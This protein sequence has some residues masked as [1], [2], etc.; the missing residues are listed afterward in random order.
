MRYFKFLFLFVCTILLQACPTPNDEVLAGKLSL[1]NNSSED[2]YYYEDFSINMLNSTDINFNR[3]EAQRL[4]V[5]N[6]K[7]VNIYQYHFETNQKLY[8]FIFK[9]S[10]I[11]NHSWEEIQEQNLYDKRYSFTLDELNAINWE[12][13]YDG[14]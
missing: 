3:L 6:V 9:Q 8:L 2:F 10:T 11:D 1:K 13:V 4:T 7:E 14:N 5:N 12:L